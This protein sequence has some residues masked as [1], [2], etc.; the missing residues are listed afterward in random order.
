MKEPNNQQLNDGFAE[1]ST[2]LIADAVIRLWIKPRF[3]P[4]GIQSLI[5]GAKLAGRVIPVRHFGSVDVFFEAMNSAQAGDV[6]VIDNQGKMDEGCIGDLTALESQAFGIAG[7]VVWGCHRD[8]REL[9][10]IGLPV[11]SYG[12]CPFGPLRAAPREVDPFASAQFGN[13][14]VQAG[15][16]V[17]ADADGVLFVPGKDIESLLASAH[18][19]KAAERNQ[20]QEIA[21]GRTMHEQLRF[22]EYLEKRREHPTYTFREHL[23]HIGGAI[24]E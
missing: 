22:N 3:A 12:S 10:E 1:L 7:L 18:K 5:P 17:F 16:V 20:A 11:F 24:E 6:L 9:I 14:E 4:P 21:S 2:P 13:F 23:R 15:E 8:T 19:I